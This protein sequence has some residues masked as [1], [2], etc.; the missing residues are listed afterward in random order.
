MYR[1]PAVF[2]VFALLCACDE[3]T[4]RPV[5]DDADASVRTC[6]TTIVST[7]PRNGSMEAY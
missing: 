3:A 6:E 5:E 1:S 2:C 7:N 4:F